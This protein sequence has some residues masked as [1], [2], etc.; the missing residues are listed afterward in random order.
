MSNFAKRQ[1]FNANAMHVAAEEGLFHIAS[2]MVK[3]DIVSINPHI[4]DHNLHTDVKPN[5]E[6]AYR[7]LK[8]AQN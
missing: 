1:N 4:K 2:E 7:A 6:I 5:G 8:N 3:N